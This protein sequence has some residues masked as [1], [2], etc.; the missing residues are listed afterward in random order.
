[1]SDVLKCTYS[2]LKTVKTRGV[3]QIVLEMPIEGMAEAF[4]LLGAPVPGNEVWVAVARLRTGADNLPAELEPPRPAA[5]LSQIA[6]ICC[7]EGGFRRF[8]EERTGHEINDA[9]AAAKF[10]REEEPAFVAA[11]RVA[12]AG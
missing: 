10:V 1:M 6:G 8:I 9:E 7:N 12:A 2:D 3:C 5:K 4:N 11:P